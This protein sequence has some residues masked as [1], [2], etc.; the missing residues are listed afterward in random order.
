MRL[1]V[2]FERNDAVQDRMGQKLTHNGF[3]KTI[4]FTYISA[5]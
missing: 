5:F 1:D 3:E 4:S 2:Q